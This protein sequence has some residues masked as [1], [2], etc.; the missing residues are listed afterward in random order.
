[1]S[2][3]ICSLGSQYL[4]GFITGGALGWI[5]SQYLHKR[6]VRFISS[7]I[8]SDASADSEEEL[9][10]CVQNLGGKNILCLS[11]TDEVMNKY[12]N[13]ANNFAQKIGDNE[14]PLEF[15]PDPASFTLRETPLP[16]AA[17]KRARPDPI[18]EDELSQIFE[19]E[20]TRQSR[21]VTEVL[22]VGRKFTPP[23]P[24]FPTSSKGG[25]MTMGELSSNFGT[26]PTTLS[27]SDELDL[28]NL[29][30]GIVGMPLNQAQTEVAKQGYSI[31][32]LYCGA[33]EKMPASTYSPTVIG[34]RIKDAKFNP[35]TRVASAGA[36][37]SEIVDIGGVDAKDRGK[38]Q[39]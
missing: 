1:M 10:E 26:K 14:G 5:F 20:S 35:E 37:V 24:V 21:S 3:N 36:T 15:T 6:I 27:R 28:I 17:A 8:N 19:T 30:R 39:L 23:A 18:V 11:L 34:V 25:Y 32:V 22:D 33:G 16:E 31:W 4:A 9:K 29:F 2:G 38:I 13:I 12:L 7:S